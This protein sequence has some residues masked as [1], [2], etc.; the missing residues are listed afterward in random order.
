MMQRSMATATVAMFFGS[1]SLAF[2]ADMAVKAPAA[3]VMPLPIWTGFY[4]GVNAGGAF[5]DGSLATTG[6]PV[7]FNP[8]GLNQGAPA[9]MNALAAVLN[10]NAPHSG[11][12]F[13]GGG[14]FGY[15]YQFSS[16][17]VLGVE[18]DIQGLAGS[19]VQCG[20]DGCEV[21]DAVP[22]EVGALREVLA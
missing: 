15:N 18:A 19:A 22:G 8:A 5:G 21:A 7:S 17:Y 1:A 16:A 11:G 14:Q 9:T 20:G 12:Q 10:S 4:G 3:A 2:A 6:T 13:I